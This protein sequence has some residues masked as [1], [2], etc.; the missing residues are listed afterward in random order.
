MLFES[1]LGYFKR[2]VKIYRFLFEASRLLEDF[3]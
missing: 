3:Y 1:T 2:E